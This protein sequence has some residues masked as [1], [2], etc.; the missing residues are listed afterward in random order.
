VCARAFAEGAPAPEPW[1]VSALR[2]VPSAWRP[3][4]YR[5]LADLVRPDPDL[6]AALD[7]ARNRLC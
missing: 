6:V 5:A 7:E 3:R 2:T 4:V 1:P